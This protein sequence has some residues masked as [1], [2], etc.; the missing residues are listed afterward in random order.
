MGYHAFPNPLTQFKDKVI[1]V[2]DYQDWW[3]RD[4]IGDAD[5]NNPV[6]FGY[7]A[8]VANGNKIVYLKLQ[9][10]DPGWYEKYQSQS[11]VVLS[12]PLLLGGGRRWIGCPDA[13]TEYLFE[14][15][16]TPPVRGQEFDHDVA[17]INSVDCMPWRAAICDALEKMKP[18]YNAFFTRGTRHE[19]SEKATVPLHQSLAIHRKSRINISSNG[20]GMWCLKDG[21]L[22]NNGCFILREHHQN[23]S[24][25]P[26]T[27]KFGVHWDAFRLDTLQDK[28]DYWLAHERE[29]E[30]IRFAGYSYFRQGIYGAWAETYTNRLVDFLGSLDPSCF[31]D[32]LV[33]RS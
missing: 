30:D 16:I 5:I 14:N 27:P 9:I 13:N 7:T 22:F 28:V 8:A 6:D 2:L 20:A 24:I 19:Q 21:E 12:C 26:L 33:R 23:L 17:F 15:Q 11:V 32:L 1:V 25:N 4:W 18:R 3:T 10:N 29:M 31:G